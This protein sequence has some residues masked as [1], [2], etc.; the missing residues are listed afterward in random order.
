M[1]WKLFCETLCI[2]N[3]VA[4]SRWL[5]KPSITLISQSQFVCRKTSCQVVMSV[6]QVLRAV[7]SDSELDDNDVSTPV[8]CWPLTTRTSAPLVAVKIPS[9]APVNAL[10]ELSRKVYALQK[11][12]QVFN[13]H[14]VIAA[15][16]DGSDIDV[17][18]S[19]DDELYEGQRRWTMN[20]N[21][22]LQK[23]RVIHPLAASQYAKMLTHHFH[24]RLQR[25]LLTQKKRNFMAEKGFPQAR[26]YMAV[27]PIPRGSCNS[28]WW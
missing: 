7:N 2:F 3:F 22:P 4:T 12:K 25:R 28:Q 21:H 18:V 23:W 20:M 15:L 14:D 24:Q 9:R 8:E 19:D 1:A 13:A 27:R 11:V 10:R 26:F 5:R 6:Q 17:S 16:L